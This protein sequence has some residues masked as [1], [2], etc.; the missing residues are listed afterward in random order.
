MFI[1]AGQRKERRCGAWK[2]WFCLEM[3]WLGVTEL[4]CSAE[5]VWFGPEV[6]WRVPL[7]ILLIVQKRL[8]LKATLDFQYSLVL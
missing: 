6:L 7:F 4:W 1:S 8:L 2:D 3:A 5:R